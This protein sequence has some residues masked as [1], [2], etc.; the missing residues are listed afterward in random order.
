[1]FEH[2]V[3]WLDLEEGLTKSIEEQKTLLTKMCRH[4]TRAVKESEKDVGNCTVMGVYESVGNEGV[5]V[6]A[7]GRVGAC[8]GAEADVVITIANY[9]TTEELTRA[10][11]QLFILPPGEYLYGVQIDEIGCSVN[12]TPVGRSDSTQSMAGERHRLPAGQL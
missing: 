4:V 12:K 7:E 3:I 11:R 10:R 6:D 1:M 8:A 9:N 2:P 5:T